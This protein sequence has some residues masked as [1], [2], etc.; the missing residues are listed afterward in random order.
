[1]RTN[2]R[3]TMA[4]FMAVTQAI[5][6]KTTVIVSPDGNDVVIMP[7]KKFDELQE[8]KEP[9]PAKIFKDEMV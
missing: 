8:G 7:R 4:I 1:M 9:I 5:Q 2:P 3:N 6:G